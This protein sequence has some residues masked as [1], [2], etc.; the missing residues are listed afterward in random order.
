MSNFKILNY[1]LDD[2]INYGKDYP[3]CGM[4]IDM[5]HILEKIKEGYN[6]DSIIF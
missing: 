5:F 2:I 6:F 4:E 3:T 1:L